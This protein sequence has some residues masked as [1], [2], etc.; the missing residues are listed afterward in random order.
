MHVR[1][2][3]DLEGRTALVTGGG[4]GIGRHISVGLAEAGARV[5]VASRKRAN[6]EAV[7]QEIEAAGGAAAAFEADV[8]AL[9]SCIGIHGPEWRSSAAWKHLAV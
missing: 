4:R 2:L 9:P 7:V 3:F 8:E 6:C 5:L 1:E